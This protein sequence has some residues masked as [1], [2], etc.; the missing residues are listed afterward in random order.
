MAEETQEKPKKE[1]TTTELVNKV[2][3]KSEELIKQGHT[4]MEE[5][6]KVLEKIGEKPV[7]EEEKKKS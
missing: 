4:S 1:E 2:I 6:N 3:Q 7:K 5:A